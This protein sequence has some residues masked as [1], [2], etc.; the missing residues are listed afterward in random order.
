MDSLFTF[1]N[2]PTYVLTCTGLEKFYGKDWSLQKIV[3]YIL[4]DTITE[5]DCV[6]VYMEGGGGGGTQC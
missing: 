3:D 4:G 2:V 6:C 5:Q 1:I